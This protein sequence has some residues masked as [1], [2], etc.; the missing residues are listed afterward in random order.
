MTTVKRYT[1]DFIS[2]LCDSIKSE[3]S[4]EI[5][6]NLLEI[7]ENNRFIRR[8]TPIKLEYTLDKTLANTWRNEKKN[9]S[10]VPD[11]IKFSEKINSELNKISESNYNKILKSIEKIIILEENKDYENIIIDT[12]FNKSINQHMFSHLYAKMTNLFE[13]VYGESFK[14]KLI[15]RV[16]EFYDKNIS[17]TFT[18]STNYE[19]L[20]NL[21]EKK[22]KLLGIFIFIGGLYIN[23]IIDKSVVLKYYSILINFINQDDTSDNLEK[24]IDCVCTLTSNIGIKLE[25]EL[26]ED[27]FKEIFTLQ[28]ENIKNNTKKFS[29]K[30]RFK[31]MDLID[32]KTNNWKL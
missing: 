19:E 6:Q 29:F 3:L 17:E 11:S 23:S 9:D 5:I 22:Q 32:L 20:C 14:H 16:H 2:G 18:N 8:N 24:Y 27:T 4:P 31:I 10:E 15:E 28:M 30:S 1:P 26:D 25:K 12:V 13:K 21:N 7:K